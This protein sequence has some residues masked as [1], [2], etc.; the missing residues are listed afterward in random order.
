MHT[1]QDFIDDAHYMGNILSIDDEYFVRALKCSSLSDKNGERV[2]YKKW[3]EMLRLAIQEEV[4]TPRIDCQ[5]TR[6]QMFRFMDPDCVGDWNLVRPDTLEAEAALELYYERLKQKR[7]IRASR[8]RD[9]E[10]MLYI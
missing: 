10:L 6:F 8:L 4:I 2:L 5:P 3:P 1:N 9:S 7:T